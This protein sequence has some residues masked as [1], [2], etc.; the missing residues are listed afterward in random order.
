L[1]KLARQ[2]IFKIKPYVPGKPVEEVER[3]L[4]IR[5]VIKLASN[6]NPLGPSPRAVEAL[7]SA[8]GQVHFYPDGNCY[9]LKQALAAKL[10]QAPEEFMVGNGSDELLTLL[11]QAF[12][13]PGEEIIMG[14]PSFSEYDFAA[15]IMGGEVIKVPLKNFTHDLKA[16]AEQVSPLTKMIFVCNP[17]NPTGTMVPQAEVT[18]FMKAV[19]EDVLVIFDEA[20][21]EYVDDPHYPDSLQYVREGR[22]AIVLRT[23]S[24]VYG[25][26]GLRI[27]YGIAPEKIISAVNRVREPFNVNLLAQKAAL[28]ALE[29]VEFVERSKAMNR[30]EKERLYGALAKLNL[31]YIPSQANFIFIDAGLDCQVLFKK[32]LLKGVIVRT[33]DIFGYPT[34]I[35]LTVGRPAE[36]AKFLRCLQEVLE[37]KA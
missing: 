23:F 18:A 21:F 6:E 10:N 37:E 34:F 26:A 17:N 29:D 22:N 27:G 33:G 13:R 32:L 4:G 7:R 12:L 11:A 2:E 15:K 30:E 20:Y 35:R 24:K 36:N 1:D 25:L 3:E 28:A 14:D 16:M 5:D 19:P 9:Y 31:R 8:V